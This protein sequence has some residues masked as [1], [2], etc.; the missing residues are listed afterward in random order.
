ML[1]NG[2]LHRLYLYKCFAYLPY[3]I[4]N[5]S[6]NLLNK[7]DVTSEIDMLLDKFEDN[8]YEIFDK[9]MDFLE[10]NQKIFKITSSDIKLMKY[11]LKIHFS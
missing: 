11:V 7:I 8:K 5:E 1:K 9:F 4:I 10:M 3:L 2:D 6:Y